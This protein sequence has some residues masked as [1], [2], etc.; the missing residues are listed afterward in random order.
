MIALFAFA[1]DV[2]AFNSLWTIPDEMLIVLVA[3][4]ALLTVVAFVSYLPGVYRQFKEKFS[5]K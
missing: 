1:P 2:G 5:K 3:I 4:S